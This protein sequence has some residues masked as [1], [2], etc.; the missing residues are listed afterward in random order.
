MR[1]VVGWVVG[2]LGI[3]ALV[4]APVLHW[5]VYPRV[6]Q[7]PLDQNFTDYASGLGSYLD[8]STLSVKSGT[9]T[10]C[11]TA[12]GDVQAGVQSG[13]AVWD[14]VTYIHAPGQKIC[15]GPDQSWNVTNERWAFNRHTVQGENVA[16]AHPDFTASNSY[17]VFPFNVDSGTTYQYWDSTAAKPFPAKYDGTE[18]VEGRTVDKFVS[19]VPPTK[20]QSAQPLGFLTGDASAKYDVYY[21]NDDSVAL[22]DPL[23]GIVVAGTSHLKLTARLPGSDVD[24]AT[25]LDVH[26]T[27]RPDSVK[28]LT[29]LAVTNGRKLMLISTWLPL[30][31]LVLG[32]VLLA[33]GLWLTLRTPRPPSRHERAA[34]PSAAPVA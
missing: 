4:L 29:D 34:V 26:L 24:E 6:Q 17:L 23:T 22:V 9:M 7:F 3:F 1:R 14:V 20:I 10:V 5:Y 11:R 21:S 15:G 33:L 25:V 8:Y 27:E 31:C 19:V 12:Y 16:G 32:L 28:A 2:G 18:V 13:A 30:A